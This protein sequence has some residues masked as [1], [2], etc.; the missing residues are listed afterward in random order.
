MTCWPSARVL[1]A[2]G[3]PEIAASTDLQNAPMAAA[4]A[5]AGYPVTQHRYCMTPP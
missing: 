2:E 5:R 4:F 3:V 1:A